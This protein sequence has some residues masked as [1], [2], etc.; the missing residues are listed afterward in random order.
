LLPQPA[1][2]GFLCATRLYSGSVPQASLFWPCAKLRLVVL[3]REPQSFSRVESSRQAN[4]EAATRAG[5]KGPPH[6]THPCV[7]A[8]QTL[9]DGFQRDPSWSS[10]HMASRRQR[11]R[12]STT[13]GH[14]A[15]PGG[16]GEHSATGKA[17]LLKQPSLRW[18][19]VTVRSCGIRTTYPA[20]PGAKLFR[21]EIQDSHLCATFPLV[22]ARSQAIRTMARRPAQP[23]SAPKRSPSCYGGATGLSHVSSLASRPR[24]PN[25]HNSD[26][27]ASRAP[28]PLLPGLR[29]RPISLANPSSRYRRC[30]M[31]V[32]RG[33]TLLSSYPRCRG[34]SIAFL[35]AHGVLFPPHLFS[36]QTAGAFPGGHVGYNLVGKGWILVHLLLAS[37]FSC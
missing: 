19:P 29:A 15:S 32:G 37:R 30:P 22:R 28:A 18:R 33:C 12:L 27:P 23:G 11:R 34:V 25:P 2:S 1:L 20:S 14:E 16:S 13:C 10:P 24:Q 9:R 21:V 4:G 6:G 8:R 17:R 35:R 7:A 5:D 3:T 36:S 26:L 31:T